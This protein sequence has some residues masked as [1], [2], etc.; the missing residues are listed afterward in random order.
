VTC[1]PT[2]FAL[3]MCPTLLHIILT[4]K[5]EPILTTLFAQPYL[6]LAILHINCEIF[7][8]RKI[9][10]WFGFYLLMY[11]FFASILMT[12][13]ESWTFVDEYELFPIFFSIWTF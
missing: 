11:G 6:F 5:G 2:L 1:N 13:I 8:R 9:N 3:H 4:N 10:G 12:R 7:K